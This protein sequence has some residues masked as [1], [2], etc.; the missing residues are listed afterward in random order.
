MYH[1]IIL[2]ESVCAPM[3]CGYLVNLERGSSRG[4]FQEAEHHGGTK[5]RKKLP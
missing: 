4:F 3:G 5:T 2:T 1:L